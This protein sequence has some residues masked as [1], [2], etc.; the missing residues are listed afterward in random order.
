MFRSSTAIAIILLTLSRQLE[1]DQRTG[2]YFV[3]DK[4]NLR[5]PPSTK[6]TGYAT[7]NIVEH[8]MTQTAYGPLTERKLK[9]GVTLDEYGHAQDF[10]P[11]IDATENVTEQMLMEREL[12][13]A[14]DMVNTGIVVNNVTLS[15]TGQWSDYTNSDPLV[16]I[17]AR[18]SI[19]KLLG[20]LTPN[21][22]VAGQQVWDQLKN[23]PKVIDRLKYT[24]SE[25]VAMQ[26]FARL[27]GVERFIVGDAGVNGGYEGLSDSM[28]YIWGKNAWLM[29]ISPRPGKKQVS[30]FYHLTLSG[31]GASRDNLYKG[32][33]KWSDNDPPIT[34]VRVNDYY[35]RKLVAA[36]AVY[37]IFAAVA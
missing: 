19:M 14:A 22:F 31:K 7:T 26:T 13:L 24:S 33:D 16:A 11:E 3:Y 30:A 36:E 29:Y 8:N 18:I 21:T 17:Q 2:Y 9:E 15:G 12:D 10:D 28:S 5:R 6:R 34:W 27:I 1:V 20:L 4:S 32:V 35:D 23:H 37:G 25:S